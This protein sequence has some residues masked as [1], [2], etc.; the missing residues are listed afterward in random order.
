MNDGNK[1]VVNAVV[2]QI[3]PVSAQRALG[4]ARFASRAFQHRRVL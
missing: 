4:A 2:F 1:F 3:R